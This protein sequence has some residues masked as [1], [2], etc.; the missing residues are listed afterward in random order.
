M[1]HHE[2]PL[3]RT[4]NEL[5]NEIDACVNPIDVYVLLRSRIYITDGTRI[6][7]PTRK[8]VPYPGDIV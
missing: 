8:A 2:E 7:H 3:S 5:T 4:R 6:T 1:Y